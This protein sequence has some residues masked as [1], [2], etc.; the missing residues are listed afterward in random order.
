[1]RMDLCH[2]HY[3][4]P[5]L[6]S[7]TKKYRWEQIKDMCKRVLGPYWLR[8]EGTLIPLP[9]EE[10]L[11]LGCKVSSAYHDWVS[12]NAQYADEADEDV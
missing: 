7:A 12:Y 3:H 11:E 1:M 10:A 6:L 4:L 8:V 2:G 5:L 9:N